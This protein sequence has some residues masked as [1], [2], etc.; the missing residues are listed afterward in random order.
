MNIPATKRESIAQLLTGHV[1]DANKKNIAER[2]AA[3]YSVGPPPL[4]VECQYK[5][6]TCVTRMATAGFDHFGHLFDRGLAHV[7]VKIF[8][9]LPP[10]DF[11]SCGHVCQHWRRF[12]DGEILGRRHL[13]RARKRAVDRHRRT[14]QYL[15]L[16]GGSLIDDTGE[17]SLTYRHAA[18]CIIT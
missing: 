6:K 18:I 14:G 13:I 2:D 12:I 15:M 5:N 11:E 7:L 8:I 16:V 17:E 4:N 3:A 1:L 10:R 9:E